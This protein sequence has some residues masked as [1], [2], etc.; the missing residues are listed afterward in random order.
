MK[1]YLWVLH[2]I[3]GVVGLFGSILRGDF[4]ELSLYL[5]LISISAL[6]GLVYIHVSENGK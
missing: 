4:A 3:F 5:V 2:L 6:M 1:K